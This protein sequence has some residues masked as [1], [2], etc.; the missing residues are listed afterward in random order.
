MTKELKKNIIFGIFFVI[1]MLV[2]GLYI[3]KDFKLIEFKNAITNVKPSFLIM[4]V[5]MMIM[6]IMGEARK[7]QITVNTVTEKTTFF[8]ALG[9]AMVGFYF[10]SITPS[11]TGGQPAQMFYMKKDKINI[12]HSALTLLVIAIVYFFVMIFFCGI[13]LIAKFDFISDKLY[14]MRGLFIFGVAVNILIMI[15]LSAV[16]FS[17]KAVLKVSKGIILCLSKIKLIKNKEKIQNSIETQVS[18]Y[19]KGSEFIKKNPM[20]FIRVFLITFL[21]QFAMFTIT[22]FV[23]KA[24][25]LNDFTFMEII[26]LQSVLTISV[27]SLPLPGAVG[28]SENIFM[29]LFRTLFGSILIIP[30]MLLSRGISFYLLLIISGFSTLL[31]HFKKKYLKRKA[32][33]VM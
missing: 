6:F 21:Q 1:L 31:I 2:T 9:Y 14:G 25:S 15:L 28:A 5:I 13:M 10:S 7:I 12:S 3:L 16:I 18:E 29:V 23:Y 26:A 30:A 24:F 22:Y 20:I 17:K 32:E 8:K 11:S 33:T 27:S 19:S 4:A